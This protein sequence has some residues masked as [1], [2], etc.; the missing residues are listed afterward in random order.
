MFFGRLVVQY[1]KGEEYGKCDWTT[2]SLNENKIRS[3]EG[4]S[5]VFTSWLSVQSRDNA[6]GWGLNMYVEVFSIRL[7][8][9]YSNLLQ[10]HNMCFV[11]LTSG[12]V[13]HVL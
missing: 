6:I 2:I 9:L 7:L 8:V 12:L 11:I 4:K 3:I 13:S 5:F 1:G 10:G